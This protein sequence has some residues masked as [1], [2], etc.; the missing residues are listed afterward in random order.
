MGLY[1]VQYLHKMGDKLYQAEQVTLGN[2]QLS[3]LD[4]AHI[5]IRLL[6]ISKLFLMIG[7]VRYSSSEL[8]QLIVTLLHSVRL[9]CHGLSATA[10]ASP[11]SLRNHPRVYSPMRPRMNAF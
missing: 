11:R 6:L 2:T 7:C 9:R 8:L 10:Q 5:Q 4:R 1:P 3:R